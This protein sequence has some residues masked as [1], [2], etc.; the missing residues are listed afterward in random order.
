MYQ[1]QIS[2]FQYKYCFGGLKIENTAEISVEMDNGP[3]YRGGG[4]IEVG[5]I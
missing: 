4:C 2:F 3:T 5:D 1:W